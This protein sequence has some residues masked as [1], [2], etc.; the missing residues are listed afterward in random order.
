MKT[1]WPHPRH[2]HNDERRELW[3]IVQQTATAS[4]Q[5]SERSETLPESYEALSVPVAEVVY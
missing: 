2:K 3:L 5:P 4:F 1:Q